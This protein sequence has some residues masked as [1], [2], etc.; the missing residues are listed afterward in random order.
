MCFYL[1]A[2]FTRFYTCSVKL[3]GILRLSYWL[4]LNP[5]PE[6]VP[7]E[8]AFTC[9]R[10]TPSCRPMCWYLVWLHRLLHQSWFWRVRKSFCSNLAWTELNWDVSPGFGPVA[11]GVKRSSDLGCGIEHR[12]HVGLL[13]LKKGG[14]ARLYLIL[15]WSAVSHGLRSKMTLK[16]AVSVKHLTS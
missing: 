2:D 16:K 10:Q 3:K 1:S 13:L 5:K 9:R 14:R 7:G 11:V 4:R 8:N 6:A 12:G 15:K